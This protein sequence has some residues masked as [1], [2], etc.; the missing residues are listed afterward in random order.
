MCGASLGFRFRDALHSMHPFEFHLLVSLITPIGK[1]TSLN[2]L[3]PL[4]EPS[5]SSSTAPLSQP[6]SDGPP[7]IEVSSPGTSRISTIVLRNPN[8]PE[9]SWIPEFFAPA[10]RFPPP[11]PSS[12]WATLSALHRL[13]R[14][15]A[16]ML[17]QCR[18]RST[19]CLVVFDQLPQLQLFVGQRCRATG[20]VEKSG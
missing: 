11:V 16:P 13:H 7:Q 2:P 17:G 4:T 6:T 15:P 12:S 3:I 8:P 20:I 10:F 14:P 9:E 19:Q 1:V 5:C 18:F